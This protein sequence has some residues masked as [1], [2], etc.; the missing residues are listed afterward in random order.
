MEGTGSYCQIWQNQANIVRFAASVPSRT[1][2]T[3][4][5]TTRTKILFINFN[6]L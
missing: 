5:S 6:S 3:L 1:G 4:A 2:L